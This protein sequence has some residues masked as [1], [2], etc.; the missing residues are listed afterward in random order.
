MQLLLVSVAAFNL[1][2]WNCLVIGVITD[3]FDAVNF[4]IRNYIINWKFK[5][6]N[7]RMNKYIMKAKK[8]QVGALLNHTKLTSYQ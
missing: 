2:K 4:S 6:E 5:V 1:K 7:W 8:K 3:W